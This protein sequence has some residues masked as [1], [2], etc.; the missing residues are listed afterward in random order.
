LPNTKSATKA[1]RQSEKKR[2][3][4]LRKKTK[5]KA[6]VKEFKKSISE[7]DFEKAKSLL[8]KVYKSL[9]KAAKTNVI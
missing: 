8:P 4:N 6:A 3:L 9:D 7:K 5:Y 2:V 1:L